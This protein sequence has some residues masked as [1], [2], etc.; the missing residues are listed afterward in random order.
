MINLKDV[1]LHYMSLEKPIPTIRK[2]VERL[3]EERA[4]NESLD[5]PEQRHYDDVFLT[6]KM[7]RM[8]DPQ[9]LEISIKVTAKSQELKEEMGKEL[10]KVFDLAWLDA[11]QNCKGNIDKAANEVKNNPAVLQAFLGKEAFLIKALNITKSSMQE[12]I[13]Y[14]KKAPKFY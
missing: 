11:T 13:E 7:W 10:F 3:A 12:L 2:A 6:Y 8:L 1:I 9:K 14:D 4:E 5:K